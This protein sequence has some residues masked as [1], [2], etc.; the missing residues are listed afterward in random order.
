MKTIHKFLIF[1][2]A[3]IAV[4]FG[5][6]LIAVLLYSMVQGS[7]TKSKMTFQI[8]QSL[9]IR[10]KTKPH[11]A[12][13]WDTPVYDASVFPYKFVGFTENCVY[14]GVVKNDTLY[15]KHARYVWKDGNWDKNGLYAVP[16]KGLTT[17]A[18]ETYEWLLQIVSTMQGN[19]NDIDNFLYQVCPYPEN[20]YLR[21]SLKMVIIS[22]KGF[23][24]R[25][26]ILNYSKKVLPE[27]WNVYK[28]IF[29]K[30][31]TSYYY[32]YTN[33]KKIVNQ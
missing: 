1:G 32:S 9:P 14:R 13:F 4:I 8:A 25:K 33:Y 21:D 18:R 6:A 27:P 15:T 17:D 20:E 30:D 7:K 29:L 3:L 16:V 31:D 19:F 5:F 10:E 2:F 11:Y 24:E 26:K 12:R 28:K 23:F 22:E